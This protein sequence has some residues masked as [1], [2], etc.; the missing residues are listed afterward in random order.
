[1]PRWRMVLIWLGVLLG[2]CAPVIASGFSPLLAWRDPIYIAAGFA[3]VGG[4]ALM[5]LQP[6]L[7]SGL[8]PG[9]SLLHGRKMHR[10]VGVVLVV[11]VVVH[12]AGLWVTSPPDVIDALLFRSPTPFAVWGVIAMWA[13]FIAALLAAFRRHLPLRLPTWRR[14]HTLCVAIAVAGTVVHAALIEGTMETMSKTAI[15]LLTVWAT[16]HAV[17]VLRSWAPRSHKR[18]ARS[19]V[20]TQS[21]LSE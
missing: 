9:I 12:V 4:L 15:C 1:M 14:A 21:E 17:F 18:T 5:F 2:L 7:A 16:S 8:L 6:L 11:A 10:L 19:A 20:T 3:G 13:V